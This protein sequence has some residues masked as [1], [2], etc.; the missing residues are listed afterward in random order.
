MAT[1]SRLR[2]NAKW[3]KKAYFSTYLRFKKEDEEE[4]RQYAGDNLNGFIVAAVK[5]KI[6][7]I[8]AGLDK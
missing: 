4:I 5:E 2:A 6:E 8:K 3:Q 1:E 7:R